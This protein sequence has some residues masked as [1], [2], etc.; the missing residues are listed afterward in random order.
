MTD[1][2][3]WFGETEGL[4]VAVSGQK[5]PTEMMLGP[6]KRKGSHCCT[7]RC[8]AG[9]ALTGTEAAPPALRARAGEEGESGSSP[10][11]WVISINPSVSN[12]L[13]MHV[14]GSQ[15]M[16]HTDTPPNC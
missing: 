6:W 9:C 8:G 16:L 7:L 1:G 2:Q 14:L 5:L 3:S 13:E 4:A 15:K 11:P 10:A 12:V